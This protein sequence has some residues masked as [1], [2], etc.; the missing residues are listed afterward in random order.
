MAGPRDAAKNN[1]GSAPA[2]PAQPA[3]PATPKTVTPPAGYQAGQHVNKAPSGAVIPQAT[4]QAPQPTQQQAPVQP[5]TPSPVPGMPSDPMSAMIMAQVLMPW[6][7]SQQYQSE[8]PMR[9]LG[10]LVNMMKLMEAYRGGQ[11]TSD[12]EY[13]ER[14]KQQQD[15]PAKLAALGI[16][17]GTA[18]G[19]DLQNNPHLMDDAVKLEQDAGSAAQRA[20][21]EWMRAN[22]VTAEKTGSGYEYFTRN[23]RFFA[24]QDA[25]NKRFGS[26]TDPNTDA[27]QRMIFMDAGNAMQREKALERQGIDWRNWENPTL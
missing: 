5:A 21:E 9:E 6:L 3:Q 15:W 8:G 16:S 27:R 22:G 1:Q 7:M 14:A 4:R 24:G 10:M 26:Y 20:K 25:Y 19:M 13:A 11:L 2:Q 18:Q 17:P 23:G 12:D